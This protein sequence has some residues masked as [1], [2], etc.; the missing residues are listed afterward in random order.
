VLND[1]IF[2]GLRPVQDAWS[3]Y[4]DLVDCE[5]LITPKDYGWLQIRYGKQNQSKLRHDPEFLLAN[6]VK[7]ERDRS[8]L[9][10]ASGLV[11]VD[12]E[13]V[14][15]EKFYVHM[16]AHGGRCLHSIDELHS[17]LPSIWSAI[18]GKKQYLPDDLLTLWEQTPVGKQRDFVQMYIPQSLGMDGCRLTPP[19]WA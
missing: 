11:V 6:R 18:A 15:E 10:L 16:D 8:G 2:A 19:K 14:F 3:G 17:Q 7:V 13:V 12:G 1:P 5:T 4:F 9:L